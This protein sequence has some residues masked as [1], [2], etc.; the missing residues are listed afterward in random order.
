VHA[1]TEANSAGPVNGDAALRTF[2]RAANLNPLAVLEEIDLSDALSEVQADAPESETNSAQLLGTG[3][4]D[5][6]PL[7]DLGVANASATANWVSDT[8]C[9]AADTPLAQ[10]TNE[11]ATLDLLDAAVEGGL[12]SLTEQGAVHSETSLWLA[13][14]EGAGDPRAVVSEALV[15]VAAVSLA[16]ELV[17]EIIGDPVLTATATGLP[18][19]ASVEFEAPVLQINGETVLDAITL[20]DEVIEPILDALAPILGELTDL[21]KISVEVGQVSNVVEAADGTAAS[22]D[23]AVA[24]LKVNLLSAAGGPGITIIDLAIGPMSASAFAPEG[25][26]VCGEDLENPGRVTKSANAT[27]EPGGTFDYTIT[28]ENVGE[29]TMTGIS[30]T[31]EGTGPEGATITA[32]NPEASSV[33]GLNAT[34]DDLG[35]LEPGGSL[36]LTVTVQ[37]PANAASGTRFHDDAHFDYECGGDTFRSSGTLDHPEVSGVGLPKTG[38]DRGWLMAGAVGT[39]GALGLMAGR[40]LRRAGC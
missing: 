17:I 39:L 15:Q 14:I 33:D 9:V 16:G 3:G 13:S 29:C 30:A 31:E 20:G 6:Q 5:L 36:V 28:L 37:V 12:V 2:A 23:A 21:V 24:R 38:G 10:A 19:G 26:I 40:R 22:A 35:S 8:E 7:V 32:T 25:G 34:W 27:V 11:A 4:T 1:E 18:G